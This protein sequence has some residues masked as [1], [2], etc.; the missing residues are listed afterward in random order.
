MGSFRVLSE[1]QGRQTAAPRWVS[2]ASSR[3]LGVQSPQ[4][5]GIS[6][7]TPLELLKGKIR[8]PHDL[9]PFNN[10]LLHPGPQ[11]NPCLS[12]HMSRSWISHIHTTSARLTRAPLHFR[13]LPDEDLC[14]PPGIGKHVE[15]GQE[16][17]PWHFPGYSSLC[18]H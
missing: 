18:V 7:I 9:R 1:L 12:Q 6:Y 14:Y 11:T 8:K 2:P 15:G 10:N 4:L 5:S 17:A 13:H 16:A 3:C